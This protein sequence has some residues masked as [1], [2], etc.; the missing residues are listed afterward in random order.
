MIASVRFA[1]TFLFLHLILSK[2]GAS[3]MR[4]KGIFANNFICKIFLQTN[5][6]Q[7][8][9]EVYVWNVRTV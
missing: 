3:L 6:T 7:I 1:I 5:K 8:L 9:F 4:L 2:A